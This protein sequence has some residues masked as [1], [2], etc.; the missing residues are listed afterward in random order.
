MKEIYL[1]NAATTKVDKLVADRIYEVMLN[2]YGNPSSRHIKGIESENIINDARSKAAKLISCSANNIIFTSGGTESNN[3]AI[4]GSVNLKIA[5]RKNIITS[6]VEHSSVADN[7]NKLQS[8][9]FDVKYVKPSSNGD[10]NPADVWNLVDENTELV[11][12]MHVNNETGNIYDVKRIAKGIRKKKKN[13]VIHCDGVQAFGKIKVNV[14]DLDVDLYSFSGHKI[15]APKGVG[16]LYIKQGVKVKPIIIGGHQEFGYRCGTENLIGIAGLGKACEIIDIDS[17]LNHV[18][19][20]HKL[21]IDEITKIDGLHINSCGNVLPYI[22]NFSVLGKKSEV[23]LN[24]LQQEGFFVS[25]GS[26]CSKGAKSKVLKGMGLKEEYID[27]AIR[28][29][30]S[31]YNT[32]NDVLD[33]IQVIKQLII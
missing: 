27:S 29:G 23:M 33:F 22:L 5:G 3:L 28:V 12:I 7:M 15:Y 1:D 9:G 32:E 24:R 30:F 4:I 31:K 18:S 6:S 26:A 14:I 13:T 20:L 8:L 17:Q 2:N 16:G 25:S 21:L 10:I 11:S 19:Q